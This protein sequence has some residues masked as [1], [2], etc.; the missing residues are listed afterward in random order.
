MLSFKQYHAKQYLYYIYILDVN[1]YPFI[2]GTDYTSI[3]LTSK[4]EVTIRGE[5]L[6]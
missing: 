1:E 4:V 6:C 3:N 2:S 5:I